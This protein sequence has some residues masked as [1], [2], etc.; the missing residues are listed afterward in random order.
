MN[1]FTLVIYLGSNNASQCREFA[2]LGYVCFSFWGLQFDKALI[3]SGYYNANYTHCDTVPSD[4]IT[5]DSLPQILNLCRPPSVTTQALTTS[6]VT[7]ASL[8]TSLV[9]SE[10]LTTSQITSTSDTSVSTSTSSGDTGEESSA[11]SLYLEY[12]VC[13]LLSL[14]L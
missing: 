11:S 8:T 14:M 2:T 4:L 5:T 1:S 9:T 6:L 12:F 13:F 10:S 3:N 7:S